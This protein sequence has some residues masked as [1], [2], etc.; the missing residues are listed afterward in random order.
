MHLIRYSMQF[1]SWKERRP[2]AVALRPIYRAENAE[3]AAAALEAFDRDLWAR[4]YPAIAQSWRRNWEAV[5]PFFAFPAE[6]RKIIYTTDENNKSMIDVCC[7]IHVQ[8]F[9]ASI[10]VS[11]GSL[12]S[13]QR[14]VHRRAPLAQRRPIPVRALRVS[15]NRR[16]IHVGRL[17]QISDR[18]AVPAP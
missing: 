16:R 12:S 4:K 3:T 6:V 11:V 5:I 8:S 9:S 18:T 15:C 2:I 14:S 7:L 10:F 13:L 17:S 1:G